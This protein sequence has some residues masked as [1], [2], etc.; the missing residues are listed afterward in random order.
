MT[1]LITK[2][3]FRTKLLGFI[4]QCD[5]SDLSYL[6]EILEDEENILGDHPSKPSMPNLNSIKSTGEKA[7][8]RAIINGKKTLLDNQRSSGV[9][10]VIWLDIELPV[11]LSASPRR[12]CL[13]LLGS[14]DGIPV[15][16]ELKYLESSPS[17]HPV[18]GVVELLI[19]YYFIHCNYQKL[20][21]YGVHHHLILKDFKWEVI[22]NNGFPQLLLVANKAYWDYWFKRIDK[23]ELVK[24][25][26]DLGMMLDTNIHLFEAPNEDFILQKGDKPSFKPKVQSNVW[27]KIKQE[28][29]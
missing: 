26:F 5:L 11:T 12:I 29:N 10:T 27:T 14:L 8:Q 22:V 16:C 13:D 20:D 25:I 6:R 9:E 17:N 18:Y 24:Q 7:F 21:K 23:N 3:E 19:Y 15:L 1:S 2:D 4:S 28:Y